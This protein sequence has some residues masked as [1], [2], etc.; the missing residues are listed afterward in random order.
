MAAWR[1]VLRNI[2]KLTR[3]QRLIGAATCALAFGNTERTESRKEE[4]GENF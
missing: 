1:S 2:I 3:V 4:D